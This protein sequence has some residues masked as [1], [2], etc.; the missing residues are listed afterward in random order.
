MARRTTSS[1]RDSE[2]PGGSCSETVMHPAVHLGDE[3]GRRVHEQPAGD[4]EQQ[5]RRV[6]SISGCR[7]DD[8]AHQPAVARR[9]PVEAA[10][11]QPED[12]VHRPHQQA[13]LA[14]SVVRLQQERAQRR[15]QGQRVEGG[16]DGRRRHRHGELPVEL[17]GDAAEE[18]RR[19]EHRGQHQRDGDQRR[20][21]LVHGDARGLRRRQALAQLA[22]DVLD[23]DDRVVDDDADGE[24]QAEQRQH[25][26][27]EA[28]PLHHREGADE[29]YGDGDERDDRRAPRLQEQQHDDDDQQR[30]PRGS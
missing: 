5:P 1:V 8:D 19:D 2:A 12:G 29:R 22:L 13:F 21:D 25:V 10:I 23:D 7:A 28:E 18:R 27:R 26:D 3:P 4:A 11:E 17:P 9:Q 14:C 15:A 24:H 30:P 6:A 16:D 20:A